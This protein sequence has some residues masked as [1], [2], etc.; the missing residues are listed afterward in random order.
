MFNKGKLDVCAFQ[1]RN[2]GTHESPNWQ[3]VEIPIVVVKT[4]IC[5]L[6]APITSTST[7]THSPSLAS[8]IRTTSSTAFEHLINL[9]YVLLNEEKLAFDAAVRQAQGLPS[10]DT[11]TIGSLTPGSLTQSD[12][13]LL[14][15]AYR[16]NLNKLLETQLLP[17]LSGIQCR[18][19]S[20]R[21]EMSRLEE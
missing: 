15:G 14:A 20:R 17:L 8:G 19:H 3:R 7:S 11:S 13:L 6:E 2:L 9:N 10:D 1:S 16:Q 21:P 18:N 12:T 4:D 5:R